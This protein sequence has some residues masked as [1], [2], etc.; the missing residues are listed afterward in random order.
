MID[1][2]AVQGPADFYFL[3]H[4]ESE[5]NDARVLQGRLD[6]PLTEAGREQARRASDWLAGRG[7]GRLLSSPLARARQTAEIL[8]ERLELSEVEIRDELNELDIGLFT[9]LTTAQIRER[10]PEA[11]RRFQLES[12]EGV[13]GAERI[14]S[15]AARS[16]ALWR[17]LSGPQA[18]GPAALCV[19]HS[20]I[21]QWVLKVTWG[22]RTWMPVVPMGNCGICLFRVDNR[23][24]A[25]PPRYYTEWSLINH[26]PL[27][28]PQA[29]EH[30]FLKR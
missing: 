14:E 20:G 21:L 2:R 11:W 13:P 30:L 22:C 10:H 3:R 9:G 7:I 1:F 15:L 26:R 18:R 27:G 17:L 24:D 25:E 12:W 4:G 6:Y 23:P 8:A 5:G 16:E 28:G 19:T 29:D